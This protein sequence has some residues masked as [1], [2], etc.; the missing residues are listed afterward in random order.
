MSVDDSFTK[1]LLHMDGADTSQT[2]TDE[3]G[4]TWTARNHAQ[5]D[6][7]QSKFG[8]ASGLFDGTDDWIDTP[9]SDDWYLDDGSNNNSWTIDFWLKLSAE[10][11][12]GFCGQFVNTSNW[13]GLCWYP[14]TLQLVS[15]AGGVTKVVYAPD[16][17][18]TTAAGWTHIAVVKDGT[19]GYTGYKNGIS[20]GTATDTDTLTNLAAILT[21]GK[22]TDS[23][24]TVFWMHGW[25]EEFR[26]SKGIARWTANFTPPISPY[27]NQYIKHLYYRGHSRLDLT[28]I[29]RP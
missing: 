3:S 22:T 24:S 29:S 10:H 6:T 19:N 9:D 2:F 4:K 5:I 1:S 20:L 16:C 27:A 8:G 14:N 7:A 23:A 11:D 25:L 26:I 21:I 28:K 13:W 18:L 15:L 12:S 17:T